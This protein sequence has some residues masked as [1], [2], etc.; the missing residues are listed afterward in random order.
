MIVLW[1]V[2][3]RCRAHMLRS[4]LAPGPP[5]AIVAFCSAF[6]RKSTAADRLV[7]GDYD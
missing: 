6:M 5:A 1:V 2:R 3:S 7:P 4:A